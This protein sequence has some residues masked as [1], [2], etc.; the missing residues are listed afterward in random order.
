MTSENI[1]II[2]IEYTTGSG[3]GEPYIDWLCP[4]CKSYNDLR[5]RG[6]EKQ[7]ILY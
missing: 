2:I 1:S 4:Y 7:S 3:N 6:Y 5:P